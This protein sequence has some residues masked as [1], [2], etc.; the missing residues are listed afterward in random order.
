V[1]IQRSNHRWKNGASVSVIEKILCWLL[2]YREISQ[3][4][5]VYM[6]RF[7]LSPVIR[8]WQ[9]RLH[10]IMRSDWD[11]APHDHP[12][13]FWSFMLWGKYTEE[14][15]YRSKSYGKSVAH[16][17]GLRFRRA[18]DTHILTLKKPC[19]TLVLVGPTIRIW[20]FHTYMG[21]VPWYK[22]LGQH[23]KGPNV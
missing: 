5:V 8:G 15:F 19:W 9:L 20:G 16:M 3:R 17:F 13:D 4:G 12:Y 10:H 6:R 11:R 14:H 1:G 22:Y 18:S 7:Y 23:T 2:K 21:W